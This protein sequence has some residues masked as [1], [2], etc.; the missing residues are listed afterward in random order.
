[1]PSS[2]ERPDGERS[3]IADQ[4]DSFRGAAVEGDKMA[5]ILIV[6]N[7]AQIRAVLRRILEDDGHPGARR[8]ER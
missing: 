8:R 5:S 7:G 3:A 2:C 4:A 6:D 1:M